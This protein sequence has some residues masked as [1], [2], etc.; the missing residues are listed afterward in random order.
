MTTELTDYPTPGGYVSGWFGH[1]QT[2]I[3]VQ[4]ARELG[5]EPVDAKVVD[6]L[7][8]TYLSDGHLGTT[9]DDANQARAEAGL[10]V[11][12]DDE[13]VPLDVFEYLIEALDDAE[14]W[15]DE[16]LVDPDLEGEAHWGHH[17]DIGEW[18]LW[19]FEEELN[20]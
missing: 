10:A 19:H 12:P 8:L 18:G 20:F 9:R 4:T 16:N 13:D 14:A 7:A 2:A 3:A 5:W 17:P 1:Y 15:L 6:A 11:I